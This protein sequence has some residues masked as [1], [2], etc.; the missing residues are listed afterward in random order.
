MCITHTPD[1][2]IDVLSAGEAAVALIVE[3]NPAGVCQDGPGRGL[4]ALLPRRSVFR[5]L[6][7]AQALRIALRAV[8]RASHLT[9]AVTL[10]LVKF[11]L[12]YSP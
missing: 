4:R 2:D 12:A 8:H 3:R 11:V 7:G 1:R 5:V 9:E 6:R 10:T